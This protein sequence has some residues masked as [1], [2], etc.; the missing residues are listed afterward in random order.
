VVARYGLARRVVLEGYDRGALAA[1]NFAAT[2]PTRVAALYLDSPALDIFSWPGRDRAS[3]EWRDCLAAY[4][5]TEETVLG[6]KGNAITRVAA[7]GAMKIPILVIANEADPV[8]PFAENA[9]ALEKRYRD[10][11]G[12]IEVI[13]KPSATHQPNAD[14]GPALDFLNKNVRR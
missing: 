8:V 1:F 9:G 11:G 10:A 4:E 3:K 12:P 13:R 6:F 5:L 14:A 7:I 2:H